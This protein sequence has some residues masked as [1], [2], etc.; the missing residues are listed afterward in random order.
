MDLRAQFAKHGLRV[1]KS[2]RWFHSKVLTA[3]KDG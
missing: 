2:T 1:E 3:V